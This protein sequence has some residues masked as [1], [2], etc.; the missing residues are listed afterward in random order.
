[1]TISKHRR[2]IMGQKTENRIRLEIPEA[3]VEPREHYV[4]CTKTFFQG[5]WHRHHLIVRER[6]K[7]LAEL[8]ACLTIAEELKIRS[9]SK[10]VSV[11]DCYLVS[12]VNKVKIIGL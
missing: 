4:V 7:R 9:T 6:T 11:V 5:K 1:M 12:S 10:G 8:T 3:A 2:F